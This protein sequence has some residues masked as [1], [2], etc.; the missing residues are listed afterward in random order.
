MKT[1]YVVDQEAQKAQSRLVAPRTEDACLYV[2]GDAELHQRI[3]E[4]RR[5]GSRED[6]F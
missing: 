2:Y 1:H 4:D 5:I 6:G 3:K